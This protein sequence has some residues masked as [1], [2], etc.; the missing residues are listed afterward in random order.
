M[1]ASPAAERPQATVGRKTQ[2]QDQDVMI[3]APGTHNPG[4]RGLEIR[5]ST[6]AFPELRPGQVVHARVLRSLGAG[7]WSISLGGRTVVARSTLPLVPGRLLATRV[8][9]RSGTLLLRIPTD[10]SIA[11]FLRSNNLGTDAATQTLVEALMRSGL[12]LDPVQI[13][14]LRAQ[15]LARPGS[16]TVSAERARLLA[17]AAG[18]GIQLSPEAVESVAGYG[19]GGGD[20]RRRRRGRDSPLPRDTVDNEAA[21]SPSHAPA[22]SAPA[23]ATQDEAAHIR[24]AVTRT[25]ATADHPLQLFNLAAGPSDDHWMIVPVAFTDRG[26]RYEA[27]LRLC[28][29]RTERILRRAA[30]VVRRDDRSWGFEWRMHAGRPTGI[31]IHP[32]ADTDPLPRAALQALT[33]SLAR[34]GIDPPSLRENSPAPNE[35]PLAGAFDGFSSEQPMDIMQSVQEEA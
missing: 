5:N 28:F 3:P 35:S 26:T 14:R 13:R 4:A 6:A 1:P 20:G 25:A 17:L 22:P 10:S 32:D 30:L 15:L 18:K 19:G 23:S 33:D 21:L 27:S 34:L 16:G 7:R 9:M 12:P 11:D 2:V 29:T 31:V 24:S 8:D